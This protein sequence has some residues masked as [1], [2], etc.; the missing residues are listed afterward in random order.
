[1]I[2]RESIVQLYSEKAEIHFSK[3][4]RRPHYICLPNVYQ[5]CGGKR[6]PAVQNET[7]VMVIPYRLTSLQV[8]EILHEIITTVLFAWL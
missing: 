5:N 2:T 1:M 7:M 8:F 4:N 6:K 3:T